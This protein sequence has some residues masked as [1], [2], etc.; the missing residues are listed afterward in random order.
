MHGG[1]HSCVAPPHIGSEFLK[2]SQNEP[3]SQH[4]S[5]SSR[6]RPCTN[7]IAFNAADYL[8]RHEQSLRP[9]TGDTTGHRPRRPRRRCAGIRRDGSPTWGRSK[10]RATHTIHREGELAHDS[11]AIG[12]VSSRRHLPPSRCNR[13]GITHNDKDLISYTHMGN[14]ADQ[15]WKHIQRTA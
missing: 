15:V 6:Q 10:A 2:T 1:Y 4:M 14:E 9:A 11:R 13:L 3:V 5:N 8:C 7:K 12:A